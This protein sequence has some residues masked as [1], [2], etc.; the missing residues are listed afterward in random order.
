MKINQS[1]ALLLKTGAWKATRY[2]SD[3]QVERV[4]RRRYLRSR[5]VF[6]KYEMDFVVS[7]GRPN[8]IDRK[9]IKACE[10]AGESFPIKKVQLKFLPKKRK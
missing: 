3:K 7:L 1:I 9:F 4:T 6:S 2:I 8:Y 5:K 10:K